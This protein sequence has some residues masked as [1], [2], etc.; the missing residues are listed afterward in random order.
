MAPTSLSNFI[1][2]SITKPTSAAALGVRGTTF[3]TIIVTESCTT[4]TVVVP[5]GYSQEPRTT[6]AT[7]EGPIQ[8]DSSPA[9][10][11]A[12]APAGSGDDSS[13]TALIIMGVILGLSIVL[14]TICCFCCKRQ[15]RVRAALGGP[16]VPQDPKAHRVSP[17]KDLRDSK[18]RQASTGPQEVQALVGHRALLGRPELPGHRES[19]DLPALLALLAL[20]EPTGSQAPLDSPAPLSDMLFFNVYQDL[21]D[22]KGY[23]GRWDRWGQWGRLALRDRTESRGQTVKMDMTDFP[24]A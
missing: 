23:R 2:S 20:V 1:Q 7:Q 10:A 9:P 8:R 18:G 4:S 13:T 19:K 6:T 16:Q 14:F 5:L 17:S 15:K 3:V 11:P 22:L 21:R 24:G 12:P